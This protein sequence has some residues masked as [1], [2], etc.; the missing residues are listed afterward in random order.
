[1]R[2]RRWT[3]IGLGVLVALGLAAAALSFGSQGIETASWIAGVASP[4]IAV[5]AVV[6]APADT[7]TT[8]AAPTDRAPTPASDGRPA[9]IDLRGSTAVQVGDHNTQNLDLRSSPPW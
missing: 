4:V 7:P 8:T 1:M 2:T 3:V 9:R 5:A 6:L